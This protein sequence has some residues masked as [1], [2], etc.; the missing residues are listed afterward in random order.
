MKKLVRKIILVVLCFHVVYILFPPWV[1]LDGKY[2]IQQLTAEWFGYGSLL[3]GKYILYISLGSS[4]L[5]LISYVGLFLFKGWGRTLFVF[6]ITF[7]LLMSPFLGLS[8]QSG[9][10][11]FFSYFL[12][13]AQG[14]LVSLLY[15]T[16]LKDVYKKVEG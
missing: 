13:L 14:I 11:V 7:E 5:Y 10:Q 2:V 1:G 6:L 12:T 9:F 4:I 3:D 8:I 16:S 15:F